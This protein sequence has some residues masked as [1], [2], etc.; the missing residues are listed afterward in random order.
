MKSSR[1]SRLVR[2]LTA[3]QS[4][5]NYGVEEL[6]ALLQVSKRT[7]FRD[8]KELESVG[9]PCHFDSKV[10]GY[11]I[12]P[13]FFL[14][15]VNF[16]LQEALSLLLLVQNCNDISLPFK[17]SALQAGIKIE[18]NLPGNIQRYCS[19]SLKNV[20][21]K[22]NAYADD[23]R[24]DAHFATLQNSIRAKKVIQLKYTSIHEN[25]TIITE[26]HPYH[27]HFNNRAWYVIG[28]S[29]NHEQIRTFKIKRIKELH[30]LSRCFLGG[31]KFDLQDY[32]GKAWSM[33]PEGKMHKVSLLFTPRVAR[34]VAEVQWHSSQKTFHNPDG[35]VTI[36][37][38]VDG[39]NEI[40]W[41][42]LG[43]GD[44]VKVISPECLKERI[45]EAAKNVVTN[46]TD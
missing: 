21:I 43:Y 15:P 1:V 39:L 41:W 30:V 38:R 28:Y 34:S 35:S 44:Q 27:L 5:R 10:N 12:D 40:C 22:F 16:T 25:K 37:F 14:Q 19:A 4:G 7:I 6:S 3:L 20:S 24:L 29:E 45:V 8:L 9:V 23:D 17:T 13:D 26:I 31:D 32:L 46:H 42:I 11:A 2:I 18:C 33:I 36:E